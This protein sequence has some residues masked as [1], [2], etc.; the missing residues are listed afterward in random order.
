MDRWPEACEPPLQLARVRML[1]DDRDGALALLRESK[2]RHAAGDYD[3]ELEYEIEEYEE[4]A[5]L[6]AELEE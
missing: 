6:A 2:R 4:I 5:E 1:R 3:Y